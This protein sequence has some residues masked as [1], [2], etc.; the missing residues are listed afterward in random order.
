VHLEIYHMNYCDLIM[1]VP[2][3]LTKLVLPYLEAI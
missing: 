3:A 2:L 1:T